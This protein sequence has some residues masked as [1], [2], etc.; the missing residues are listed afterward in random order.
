[1]AKDGK[2]KKD[3]K[4]KGKKADRSADASVP[5]RQGLESLMHERGMS[6]RGLAEQ[7][8]LSAGY[9]N[10]IV[11]G[12]RPVPSDEVIGRIASALGVASD[13]FTEYRIRQI[14]AVLERKPA[15]ADRTYR[16]LCE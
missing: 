6:Y 4:S 10:H 15:L 5:F 7:I 11:H 12:N 16:D 13:R 3:G 8:G 14:D 9:L 1:M 2:K